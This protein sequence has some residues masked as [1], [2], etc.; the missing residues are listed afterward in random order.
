MS[1]KKILSFGSI[2]T[3]YLIHLES[4]PGA[5]QKVLS[6]NVTVSS[7]GMSAN[8]A[9]AVARIGCPSV[10]AGIL[11]DEHEDKLHID[12]FQK[13]GV[14]TDQIKFD[15]RYNLPIVFVVVNKDGERYI[16]ANLPDDN[17]FQDY[18][19]YVT[20]PL[21]DDIGLV[22]SNLTHLDTS[23]KTFSL[24]KEKGILTCV[25]LEL[26]ALQK[27]SDHDLMK[28]VGLCNII[29]INKVTLNNVS[30]VKSL[31]PRSLLDAR[32][33]D[34]VLIITLGA[35]G[36]VIIHNER[37][38]IIPSFTIDSIDTTG[39]GD[40]FAAAFSCY[41]VKG[42]D[43]VKAGIY[44][45]AAAAISTTA[46]GARGNLPTHDMVLRLINSREKIEPREVNLN[47]FIKE[48]LNRYE[49]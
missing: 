6:E 8:Y 20:D 4:F 23:L 5:D 32:S 27:I 25:D 42:F 22:Y 35:E 31:D 33:P 9:C 15:P 18:S 2:A 40:C 44:A 10:Y 43:P 19:E 1:C 46:V 29:I 26:W 48:V 34:S 47:H 38:T 37:C 14:D 41:T 30:T 13:F 28:A 12:E 49:S 39:A 36:S 7:G 45:N 17:Q 21:F 24:A 16:I 3:D 11:R